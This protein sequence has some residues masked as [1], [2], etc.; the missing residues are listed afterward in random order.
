[1]AEAHADHFAS[2]EQQ[3]YAARLGMWIFLASEVLLFTGMFAL[4]A[5]YRAHYPQGFSEGISAD[6]KWDGSANTVIL[7]FSSYLVARSLPSVQAGHRKRAL[8]LLFA[9]LFLGICFLVLKG[10]EYAAHFSDGIYPTPGAPYF[11]QH[12]TP[13]LP[14]FFTLYFLMTGAH[15]I[16]VVV[17]MIVLLTLA[18]RLKRAPVVEATHYQ[19]EI[20]AMYWH[21]VDVIWIFLWPLYYLTGGH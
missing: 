14:I 2:F 3:S 18:L 4:Y 13:G 7:L 16:H 8:A 19:L 6:L 20:G 5:G 21:L 1:M 15:A 17:G 9:V 12:T 10:Y 11:L